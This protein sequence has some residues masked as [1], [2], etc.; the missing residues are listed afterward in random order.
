[1]LSLVKKCKFEGKKE[2]LQ[3]YLNNSWESIM[4]TMKN[5]Y[6]LGKNQDECSSIEKVVKLFK[7]IMRVMNNDFWPYMQ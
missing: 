2:M 4:I 7:N 6:V 1:M 3:E 5:S